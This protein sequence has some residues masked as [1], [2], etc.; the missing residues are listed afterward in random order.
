MKRLTDDAKEILKGLRIENNT[1]VITHGALER[2]LYD[3]VDQ[4]LS[5]L[6][7]KWDKRLGGHSFAYDPTDVVYGL[8]ESGVLPDKNPTA[9]FPTPDKVVQDMLLMDNIGYMSEK[10]YVYEIREYMTGRILEPSAGT[11]A[12]CSKLREIFPNAQIDTVE[13]L[14]IN[15]L[16]LK[17][18]G[19]DPFCGDFMHF[20]TDHG[21]TYNR[22]F[23]NPPFSLASDKKAYISHVMH[24]Y[25]MLDDYGELYA[26]LPIGFMNNSTKKEL[27]FYDHVLENGLI[28]CLDK[29]SFKD[30]GTLI[31]TVIVNLSKTNWK[32]KPSNGFKSHF[33]Y[34]L[35]LTIGS[36]HELQSKYED[37]IRSM[38]NKFNRDKAKAYF[39]NVLEKLNKQYHLAPLSR[40]DEYI[41]TLEHFFI[42]DWQE[43]ENAGQ[44]DHNV[45]QESFTEEPP[46]HATS[47][48]AKTIK[49]AKK[50]TPN[51]FEFAS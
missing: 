29:E 4:A 35:F 21:I 22:I 9:F 11:G 8:I 42:L 43:E 23:M 18:Q 12:I 3:E 32:K 15:Q 13:Y 40:M 5:S 28:Q 6:Q 34:E 51:L 27:A 16:A 19:F 44:E 33:S 36:D 38:E 47:L 24:A 10:E 7:G 17:R 25:E 41:D 46:Q 2:K 37:T 49:R 39:E 45:E 30:A 31:D 50:D 48:K 20:N 14:D 1:A 26:I